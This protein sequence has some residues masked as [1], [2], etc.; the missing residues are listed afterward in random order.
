MKKKNYYSREMLNGI[1]KR[2]REWS[3]RLKKEDKRQD[4]G[5]SLT[6]RKSATNLIN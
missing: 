1:T 3:G 6:Y 5:N 2:P 4:I